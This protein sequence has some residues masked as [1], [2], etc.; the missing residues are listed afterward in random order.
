MI[1][2]TAVDTP[3][4][5]TAAF[6]MESQPTSSSVE[7]LQSQLAALQAEKKAL[8]QEKEKGLLMQQI[9]QLQRETAHLR[10]QKSGAAAASAF[11]SATG[12]ATPQLTPTPAGNVPGS[13]GM[14]QASALPSLTD[15]RAMPDLNQQV[16]HIIYGNPTAAAISAPA[17]PTGLQ[18]PGSANQGKVKVLTP[19]N[20]AHRSGLSELAYDRLSIQE[21]VVGTVRIMVNGGISPAE[22][23]A[24]LK[25]LLDV[26]ILATHYQWPAVRA[27]YGAALK[28][29]EKGHRNWSDPLQDLK[30]EMLKPSDVQ[31]GPPPTSTATQHRD[32][33]ICKAFNYARECKRGSRCNYRHICEECMKQRKKA[34]EH[35]AQSC[36]YQEDNKDQA[37][38]N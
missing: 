13:A 16:N 20:F 2:T 36:P 9:Q 14:A 34:M 22:R 37:A 11:T 31:R 38:K 30:E 33:E 12:M 3:I 21:F 4:S 7:E 15:L 28:E 5:S 26:M 10:A 1:T 18:A 17:E 27:L 24:R 35:K 25:H 19:E 29:I 23:E 32:S 8:E 6:S